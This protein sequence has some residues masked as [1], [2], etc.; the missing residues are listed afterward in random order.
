MSTINTSR[1]LLGGLA[2]GLIINIS[3]FVLNAIV[4]DAQW[5]AA[6]AA[7]G[8]PPIESPAV[9][10]GFNLIGF[11]TGIAMVWLYAAIRPRYGAG[12]KT[13]LIAAVAI[14]V[15]YTGLSSAGIML[16][17]LFPMSLLCTGLVW[18]L[19]E[20]LVAGVVGAALYKEETAGLASA[21][22]GAH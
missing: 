21:A 1:V 19:G 12:Q 4:L 17:D 22:S 15:I 8:R 10:A 9:I 11:V 13:A 5:K 18:G 2:A 3:E 20:L 6:M 7:L 16:M 14:W